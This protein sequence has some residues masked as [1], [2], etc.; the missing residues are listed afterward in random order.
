[1][2]VGYVFVILLIFSQNLEN[3]IYHKA[4]KLHITR[5]L[6][7][8]SFWKQ[9]NKSE[10]H[11][12]LHL[13]GL[14]ILFPG[15]SCD[16]S[17]LPN[18]WP[19]R[20]RDNSHLADHRDGGPPDDD[21]LADCCCDLQNWNN[22]CVVLLQK[23]GC[24]QTVRPP[25]CDCRSKSWWSD[26]SRRPLGIEFHLADAVCRM[27]DH[28]QSARQSPSG[29][30]HFFQAKCTL[31]QQMCW[32]VMF[33]SGVTSS[34]GFRVWNLVENSAATFWGSADRSSTNTSSNFKFMEVARNKQK[35]S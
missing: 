21:R 33:Q 34:R 19:G 23:C 35:I 1:M 17:G 8:T 9:Y 27:I 5:E 32:N 18:G 30:P 12:D 16:R 11:I 10:K 29:G 24:W 14:L 31:E 15:L 2:F 26:F 6:L 4:R 13:S 3:T 22:L 20:P 28:W 25:D 7:P